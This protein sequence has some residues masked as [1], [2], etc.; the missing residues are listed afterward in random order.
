M[1]PS[2]RYHL[3]QRKIVAAKIALVRVIEEHGVQLFLT[4]KLYERLGN[5]IGARH[6][7][8]GKNVLEAKSIANL[9][10]S[11]QRRDICGASV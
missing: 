6:I 7:N 9:G 4:E 5:A 3:R 11:A 1:P 8:P 10:K 2:A